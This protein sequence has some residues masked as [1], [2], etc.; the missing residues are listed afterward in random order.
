MTRG[1]AKRVVLGATVGRSLSVMNG[2]PEHLVSEGW[3]VHL[4]TSPG[5]E[6]DAYADVEGV[7]PFAISMARNPSLIRD[8]RSLAAWLL[9]L[10]RIKPD[11][12]YVGTPKAALLANVAGLICRVPRRIY[13]L[14]G[15]RLESTVGLQFHLLRLMEMATAAA[16]HIVLAVSPSLRAKAI[17]IGLSR[18]DKI[19][20]LGAGSSN[21]VDVTRFSPENAHLSKD[22]LGIDEDIPVVGFVGRVTD[23]KGLRV[24]ALARLVLQSRGVDH[25]FLIVGGPD[26]RA[27]SYKILK[28]AGRPAHEIGHVPDT[29][30]YY[31]LMDLMVLPT[32]REGFPNTVLEA[33]ASGVPVITTDAT[34]AVDSVIDGQT[35]VIV[36]R[37]DADALA[38][39]IEGLLADASL[40]AR[41]GR[42]G[43]AHVERSFRQED[44]WRRLDLFFAPGREGHN[45]WNSNDG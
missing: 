2:L 27:D 26:G 21:G 24:L 39:A 30:P 45:D 19:V 15:L 6:L 9:Y 43:R 40:R 34:G 35:G 12:L 33:S 25:E 10:K 31:S 36:P 37:D 32:R 18:S 17:E 22:E 7:T 3:D 13:V 29:S 11:V 4:V 5:T 8:V 14:R 42:H 28:A 44:V 38:D 23:D 1:S 16:S 20:V 41:L